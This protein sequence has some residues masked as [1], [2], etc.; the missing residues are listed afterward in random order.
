MWFFS[1]N[2]PPANFW[3]GPAADRRR[4]GSTRFGESYVLV[5]TLDAQLHWLAKCVKES[6]KHIYGDRRGDFPRKNLPGSVKYTRIPIFIWHYNIICVQKCQARRQNAREQSSG[7]KSQLFQRL[8]WKNFG[9]P[10][11]NL[12]LLFLSLS[13]SAVRKFHLPCIVIFWTYSKDLGILFTIILPHLWINRSEVIH[14]YRYMCNAFMSRV[15]YEWRTD[16]AFCASIPKITLLFLH[17][18]T[19]HKFSEN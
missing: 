18:S 5:T 15:T 14:A 10:C 4:T 13:A 11:G 7:E 2:L 12:I 17:I 8:L 19:M 9:F 3:A 1:Y 6:K 16:I